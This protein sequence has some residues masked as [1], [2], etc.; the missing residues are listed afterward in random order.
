MGY[1][2]DYICSANT[3]IVGRKG[4]INKP[5]YVEEPFWNVDTAFGL[6]AN[7]KLLLPRY[8]Y[9]FCRRFDFERLNKAVTI[10]S[11][12]KSDLLNIEMDLPTHNEQEQIVEI[13]YKIETV[14]EKRHTELETLD[15][16]IKS[17]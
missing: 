10:P 15:E 12:T 1:A 4:N 3:V 5:L 13:L 7:R 2:D 17:C 8:L 11:L 14:I 6:E 16:L 9:Y